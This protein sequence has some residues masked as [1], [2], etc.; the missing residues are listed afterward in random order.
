MPDDEENSDTGEE[1]IT[2]PFSELDQAV[3]ADL[4][5]SSVLEEAVRP[6]QDFPFD[7]VLQQ[8]M[9]PILAAQKSLA[10]Q[11]LLD[12]Q[13]EFETSLQPLLESQ[14]LQLQQSLAPAL[15]ASTAPALQEMKIQSVMPALQALEEIRI[16]TI[17][18]AA[19]LDE[20]QTVD[21]AVSEF[22]AAS[23]SVPHPIDEA[24]ETSQP[25]SKEVYP[26]EDGA[27]TTVEWTTYNWLQIYYSLSAA[28]LDQ[29]IE[30]SGVRDLSENQR[31]GI[32]L[33]VALMIYVSSAKHGYIESV[34]PAGFLYAILQDFAEE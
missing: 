1:E 25:A 26:V 8:Q 32:C 9:A 7:A 4:D 24:P 33:T 5:F 14:T 29:A 11:P 12:L 21:Y 6:L 13:R 28:L 10:Q 19:A 23:T 20:M 22:A 18:M 3:L 17:Q 16:P 27:D 34:T 31:V 2:S 15:A 30:S